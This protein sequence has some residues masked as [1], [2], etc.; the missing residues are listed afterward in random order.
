MSKIYQ[1]NYDFIQQ[2]GHFMLISGATDKMIQSDELVRIQVEM[3]KANEIKGILPIEIE[4][5]DFQIK[6]YYEITG[7]KML[8]HRLREV[9][10][11]MK[12]LYQLLGQVVTIIES[13]DEYMLTQG[14]FVLNTDFIFIG[15]DYKSVDL[16]YLPLVEIDQKPNFKTEFRELLFNLVGHVD[17]L[18]GNGVQHLTQYLQETGFNLKELKLILNQLENDL[19][20]SPSYTS[21]SV[22]VSAPV[23]APEIAQQV[24]NEPKSEPARSAPAPK[25]KTTPAATKKKP[26]AQGKVKKAQQEVEGDV[27][28]KKPSLVVVACLAVFALALVWKLYESIPSNIMFII[29]VSLSLVI[30]AVSVFFIFIYEGKKPRQADGNWNNATTK[31]EKPAPNHKEQK[32]QT[33]Q[34]LASEPNQVED[35]SQLDQESIV[36]VDS[37]T[38]FEQLGNQTTLL[39]QPNATVLLDED[40]PTPVGVAYLSV[41]R[42]GQTEKITI[43]QSPFIVGRNAATVDYMED[44]VGISRMHIEISENENGYFVKDLGS[45]NGTKQND[46]T[47]VAY[48]SYPLEDGDQIMVGK[49]EYT[50]QKG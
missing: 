17:E 47:I 7:K 34:Q 8:A 50:F 44:S 31:K 5:I 37:A 21:G 39:S 29:S 35:R 49:I 27:E 25:P 18:T 46:E 12:H 33:N 43:T 4:E 3:L 2:N 9:K 36:Q 13:S 32:K 1:L 45:K 38:Y 15:K 11:S 40:R 10:L 6:L 20:H 23:S 16:L 14:N 19:P 30:V 42:N 48:K 26:V 28:P 22:Q 24:S 41:N